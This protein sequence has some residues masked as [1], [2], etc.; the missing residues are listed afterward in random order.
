[1]PDKP[2]IDPVETLAMAI[3]AF[4]LGATAFLVILSVYYLTIGS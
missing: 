4:A 1:M 3:I 2:R